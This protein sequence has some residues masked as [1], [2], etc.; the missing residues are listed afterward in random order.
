MPSTSALPFRRHDDV[1]RARHPGMGVLVSFLLVFQAAQ[2]A[3]A[4]AGDLR[5]VERKVLV[6]GHLDRYRHQ[7]V[8]NDVAAQLPAAHA[9]IRQRSRAS[10]RTPI[11]RS[12]IRIWKMP[13]QILDQVPEIDP[14]VG[15]EVEQDLV[16]V[17]GVFDIDQ[18]HVQTAGRRF[19]PAQIL[20]ASASLT[21][22]ASNWTMSSGVATRMI[23]L[24]GATSFS[25][26][27][28]MTSSETN[29]QLDTLDGFND[30]GVT[31]VQQVLT[32]VEMI[33]F[34]GSVEPDSNNFR[35][36]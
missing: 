4:A 6:L 11:W 19:W 30:H 33:G 10:S 18:M 13:S 27:S 7:F 14:A 26:G 15:G 5:R 8:G 25:A 29:A 36:M 31:L 17:K 16:L 21:R 12:S 35:H 28:S 20:K 24:S 32:G 3:T 2:Q 23:S 1:A 22:L 9:H 34:S